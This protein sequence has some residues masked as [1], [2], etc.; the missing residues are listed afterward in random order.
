MVTELASRHSLRFNLSPFFPPLLR[1]LAQHH[2]PLTRLLLGGT[3]SFLGGCS[4]ADAELAL[5][6]LEQFDAVGVSGGESGL[7]GADGGESSGLAD[8]L[9]ALADYARWP[10]RAE[11]GWGDSGAGRGTGGEQKLRAA[12]ECDALLF[13]AAGAIAKA[14]ARAAEMR[15]PRPGML[16]H[17]PEGTWREKWPE[18]AVEALLG[19]RQ[20]RRALRAAARLLGPA[21]GAPGDA[22]AREMQGKQR[23]LW[24]HLDPG[25]EY[26]FGYEARGG[27]G[28]A[29]QAAG[30][31]QH[32]RRG[33]FA[34][35]PHNPDRAWIAHRKKRKDLFA[36]GLA[37]F[38]HV[39]KT[40]GTWF[41]RES[42]TWTKS[43]WWHRSVGPWCALRLCDACAAWLSIL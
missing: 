8:Y 27:A 37:I 23:L 12:V 39:S 42:V 38:Y 2:N 30:V 19:F 13:E 17:D 33:L 18:W 16:R 20:R 22:S 21:P 9:A 28:G 41:R 1:R 31:Q 10:G 15:V 6:H 14:G 40:A 11:A 4:A 7:E 25:L 34:D 35:P 26:G 29:L 32:H 24:R 43:R 3:P 36:C 5:S